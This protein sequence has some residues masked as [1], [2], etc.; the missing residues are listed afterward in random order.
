MTP[1][2]SAERI[3]KAIR[4]VCSTDEAPE[5]ELQQPAA[6]L[7]KFGD[8][9]PDHLLSELIM[10]RVADIPGARAILRSPLRF[11]ICG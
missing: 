1:Q 5:W 6:D 10:A 7:L 9:L 2:V 11:V 3:E 8:L 4:Q